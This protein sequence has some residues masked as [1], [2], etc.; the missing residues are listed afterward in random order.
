MA[1][2]IEIDKALNSK[3][4]QESWCRQDTYLDRITN[5]IY[6]CNTYDEILSKCDL[7]K[8]SWN[9]EVSI[10]NYA[11]HRWLNLQA[12]DM[13]I[14][15]LVDNGA[16]K[17]KAFDREKDFTLYG[18]NFDLKVTRYPSYLQRKFDNAPLVSRELKNKTID[19]LY[20]N[21]SQGSRKHLSNK[22]FVVVGNSILDKFNADIEHKIKAFV[23][24]Y[25]DKEFNTITITDKGKEYM[26]VSELIYV[27]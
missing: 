4:F 12:H 8:E 10:E 26:V 23:E 9:N 22:L 27:G 15:W 24:Y 17:C 2:R 16:I 1:N 20:T 5:F 19:W 11:L 6:R 13:Y 3:Y 18:V 14:D 7:N 25:A 21:Q